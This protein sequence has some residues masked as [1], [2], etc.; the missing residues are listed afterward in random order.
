[1]QGA[2]T[3]AIRS[4]DPHMPTNDVRTVTSVVDRAV[5]P[6]RFTLSLLAAFAATALLLAAL[7]IYGVLSYMVA[8]RSRE[9]AIRMALGE[10]TQQ[11]RG[12]VL[13]RTLGLAAVGAALGVVLSLSTSSLVA[14]M[15]FG[16]GPTHAGTLLATPLL[17]LAVASLAGFV[18]ALRASRVDAL[19][20][21][22]ST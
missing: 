11:V 19:S 8:E 17:L 13:A 5:S 3:V 20:T 10:S 2:V 1:I 14:S 7:G 9:I 4:I 6:R 18:P 22:Q 21:L 16:V 15:L 12:R